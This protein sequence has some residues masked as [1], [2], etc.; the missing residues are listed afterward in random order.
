MMPNPA[1]FQV[2]CGGGGPE[3]DAQSHWKSPTLPPTTGL[4][5]GLHLLLHHYACWEAGVPVVQKISN[6]RLICSR[7]ASAAVAAMLAVHRAWKAWERVVDAYIARTNFSRGKL[8]EGGLPA[9][10]IAIVPSFAPDPG[11]PGDGGGRF[12]L[13]AGR[14]SRARIC[15]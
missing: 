6:F 9:G 2:V 12:A 7:A 5:F 10:R 11:G 15:E 14:L 1:S 13:F 8:I 3:F 4:L